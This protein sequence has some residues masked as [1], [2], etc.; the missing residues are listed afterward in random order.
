M[1]AC[2]CILLRR[3][4]Q[5]ATAAYDEALAPAGIN[6]AQFSLLRHVQ[7]GSTVSLTD[8]ASAMELDRSTV[9]RNAKVLERMRLLAILPGEDGRESALAVTKRGAATLATAAPLWDGVQA[10]VASV[11]GADGAGLIDRLR[12]EL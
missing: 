8:L 3:A 11:L 2:L 9:G 10:R 7:R 4:A 6:V 1:S 5:R 12:L